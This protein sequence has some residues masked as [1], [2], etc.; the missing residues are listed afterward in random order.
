MICNLT[1][2]A[3]YLLH[4]KTCEHGSCGPVT[5]RGGKTETLQISQIHRAHRA[6][7]NA[8]MQWQ[9][10]GTLRTFSFSHEPWAAKRGWPTWK[11]DMVT[12]VPKTGLWN[13]QVPFPAPAVIPVWF[14]GITLTHLYVSKFVLF[15]M[16]PWYP[17]L[18]V[19]LQRQM[20]L[21]CAYIKAGVKEET[22]AEGF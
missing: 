5:R 10:W 3:Q 18:T 20:L 15:K 21:P 7:E 4:Q 19:M 13:I 2:F 1:H 11:T 16:N 12:P 6:A 8:G 17:S 22:D 9:L 14:W